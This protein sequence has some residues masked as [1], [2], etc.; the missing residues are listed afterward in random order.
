MKR[1]ISLAILGLQLQLGAAEVQARPNVV[2]LLVDDLGISDLACY[3]STFHESPNID[4]LAKDGILYQNAY[5]SHPVCGP[6][7]SSIMTGKLPARLGAVKI[8]GKIPKGDIIWPNVLKTQ[9]YNTYFVG[10]W[11]MGN[12]DSVLANGFD[13]NVTGNNNG[14]PSNFYFPYK[15]EL[16]SQNILGLEDGKEGDYLTDALTEKAVQL[17]EGSKDEPFLLF[18]SYYNVH[19]PYISNAQGKHEDVAYFDGKLEKMPKQNSGLVQDNRGGHDILRVP[20][21][22]NSNYAA[23]IKVV[24]DSVG[25]I[26]S[27]LENL[28]LSDNTLVI[29]T[30][31]QG[32]MCTSKIGISDSAPYSFGKA[33]LFEGGIRVPLIAK[34]PAQIQAKQRNSSVT[35]NTDLYPTLLDALELSPMP[36]Q[37]IDGRSMIKTFTGTTIPHDRTLYWTFPHNHS[38][39][40]KASIAIRKGPY[41]LLYWKDNNV[42]ELYNVEKDLAEK[43]DLS[44]QMPELKHELLK[45]LMQWQAPYLNL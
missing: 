21:Q 25:R 5:S 10:K 14:Q 22:R 20:A 1:I 33:F 8:N 17:I 13:V 30:S 7:R 23:Q 26:L 34:W 24:D 40:H 43:N 6:A 45:D 38:L 4:Q 19:K 28:G 42:S 37:H 15:S 2:F 9:G 3:G 12:S 32:S 18:M 11:H 16:K 35:L 29:F 41:K 27:T 39:G 36:E 44:K 31:D